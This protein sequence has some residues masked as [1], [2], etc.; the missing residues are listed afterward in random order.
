[1][2]EI[3]TVEEGGILLVH[4]CLHIYSHI[5]K[6]YDTDFLIVMVLITKQK[7]PDKKCQKTNWFFKMWSTW[8]FAFC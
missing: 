2:L 4:L 8:G 6:N 1:M 5:V 7:R 3:K